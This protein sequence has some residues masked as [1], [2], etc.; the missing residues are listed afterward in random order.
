MKTEKIVL[1]WETSS[2]WND[3]IT[4]KFKGRFGEGLASIRPINYN[5][6]SAY[7]KY[8][9][10][11]EVEIC[12]DFKTAVEKIPGMIAELEIKKDRFNELAR[13]A[14]EMS[15]TIELPLEKK[16]FWTFW[17]KDD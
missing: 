3:R 4:A 7:V 11:D 8:N 16:G 13:K 5:Q 14:N 1:K 17:R 12:S 9:D 6:W 10:V 15:N 2:S